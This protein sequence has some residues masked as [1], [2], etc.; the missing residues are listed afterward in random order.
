VSVELLELAASALDDLLPEVVFVGG[1]TVVLWITNPAA[2]PV[3]PTKDVDVVVE[4]TT[5]TAFHDFEARLRQR[6][7]AEDIYSGLICRWRHKQSDLI[8]DAIPADASILGFAGQWQGASLPFAIE[9]RLP[10]GA[11]IRA[12]TPP[13]LLATKIEAFNDRGKEDYLAS[14]DLADVIALIDGREEV[15]EE[16]LHAE[17]EV[18]TYLVD[19]LRRLLADPRFRDGVSAALLPDATSQARAELVVLPRLHALIGGVRRR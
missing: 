6:G 9:R 2:P 11:A 3:R 16:A 14:R 5:R 8:L 18:R 17:L 12:I 10:S 13:Y 7:F 1:A 15:V 4:V 19:E